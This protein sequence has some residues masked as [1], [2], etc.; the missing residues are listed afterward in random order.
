MKK[1][2][3]LTSGNGPAVTA[4]LQSGLDKWFINYDLKN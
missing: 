3:L 4:E 1:W 2:T